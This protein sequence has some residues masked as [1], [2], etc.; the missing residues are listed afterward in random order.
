MKKITFYFLMLLSITAYAQIEVLE[1]FED[2]ANNQIPENW[3]DTNFAVA[4]NFTCDGSEKA[5]YTGFTAAGQ[6]TLTT[7]NYTAISNGT[8]LNVSFSYN[9]FEQVSQFPPASYVAPT[10]GW[11]SLV[12]EYSTD[13]GVSWI[14]ATTIN[15]SNFTFV[16]NSTCSSTADIT[17]SGIANA[18]DFQARFVATGTTISNFALW[19]I[20]DNVS[21]TQLA[22]NIPNCDA[23][24]IS[25]LS[26]ATD[27]DIDMALTWQAATGLATGYTVSVGTTSG[28]TD[29]DTGSD[30]GTA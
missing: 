7:P 29:A 6:E 22:T 24:L 28:G 17:I 15:D 11:G 3:T 20:V 10:A 16:D 19:I 14:N 26:G 4:S 30:T 8:D 12:L 1:D 9:V 13:N 27:A 23:T 18:S 5:I 21:F 25:P 2:V